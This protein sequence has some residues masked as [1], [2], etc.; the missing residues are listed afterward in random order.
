MLALGI[1]SVLHKPLAA[2]KL[3]EAVRKALGQ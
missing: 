1:K 2:K 3:A